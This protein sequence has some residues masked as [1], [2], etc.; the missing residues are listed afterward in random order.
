M[1][2]RIHRTLRSH[3]TSPEKLTDN[4]EPV[5]RALKL[6]FK[7]VM[8]IGSVNLS[9]T[10]GSQRSIARCAY[11]TLYVIFDAVETAFVERVLAEEMHGGKIKGTATGLA[12]TR[13]EDDWLCGE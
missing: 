13:L 4:P 12:A 2:S 9:L 7:Q 5:L 8:L 3:N 11:R 6:R 10:N 1:I